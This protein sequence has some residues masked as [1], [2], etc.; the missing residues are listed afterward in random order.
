MNNLIKINNQDLQIKEFK[1]QRVVTFKD[2]DSLHQRTEGTASRNFLENRNHFIE[3][4]DYYLLSKSQN[5]EIRGFEIPNRG[6]TLITESGYLML[7]KS[8]T[9]DLA[10]KV[11]RE[12]V[13]NYFR[14]KEVKRDMSELSPQLQLLINMELEQKKLKQQLNEV[15]HHALE[16]KA[17]VQAMRDV[18]TLNPNS[19][20]SDT[21]KII[22]AIATNLGGFDHIRNVREESYKLLNTRLGVDVKTRL[23]NKRRRMA[24]EGICKSKR[25]KLTVLDVIADDKKLIEG[26]V[27]IVKEMA[28]KH[29]VA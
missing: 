2:I 16:A 15:N 28:I 22:N 20:R 18:I 3:G 4:V 6:L 13:K 23:T 5:N 12:L 26:Y 7:I 21:T 24:D 8:L 25:A 19:W 14:V 10:W 9:D 1:E 11:Q 17:E 29:K 27:A